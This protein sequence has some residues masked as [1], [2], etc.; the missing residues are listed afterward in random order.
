VADR[1]NM[2]RVLKIKGP[3]HTTEKTAWDGPVD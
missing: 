2:L 3:S 1:E